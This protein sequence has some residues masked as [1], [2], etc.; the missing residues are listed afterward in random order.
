MLYD[1]CMVTKEIIQQVPKVELHDHLDGGL[2]IQTILELAKE[3][4]VELP[5][6]D[7]QKLHD[8]LSAVASKKV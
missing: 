4:H 5:S 1:A 7:P 3:Q 8:C 2:R 6:N